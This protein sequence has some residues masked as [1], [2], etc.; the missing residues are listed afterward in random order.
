MPNTAEKIYETAK[1]LPDG[2][3]LE[4]LHY[5]EYLRLRAEDRSLA[6]DLMQAQQASMQHT[7]DNADDEVWND[8]KNDTHAR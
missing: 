7:W 6:L 4:A 3:A 2:L 1:Q 5:I 8:A